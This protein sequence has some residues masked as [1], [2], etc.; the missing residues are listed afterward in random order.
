MNLNGNDLVFIVHG[1]IASLRVGK[2]MRRHHREWVSDSVT[3]WQKQMGWTDKL[4]AKPCV[5]H[6]PQWASGKDAE[7]IPDVVQ[8]Q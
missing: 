1:G 3:E 2:A 5:V 8:R 7:Q 4:K 6:E